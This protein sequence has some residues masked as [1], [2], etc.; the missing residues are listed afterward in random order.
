MLIY[1]CDLKDAV[2]SN[3]SPTVLS[4]VRRVIEVPK[5]VL[6]EIEVSTMM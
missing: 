5:D 6:E 4:E 1:C 3:S 2:R